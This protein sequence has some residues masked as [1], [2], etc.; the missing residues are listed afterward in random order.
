MTDEIIENLVAF[1]LVNRD[2]KSIDFDG[3]EYVVTMK[4]G[5]ETTFGVK[6]EGEE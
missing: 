4:D 1:M 3:H 5:S 6:S 2:W